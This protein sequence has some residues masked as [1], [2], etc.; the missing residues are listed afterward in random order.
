MYAPQGFIL[1]CPNLQQ[2][3]KFS[4]LGGWKQIAVKPRLLVHVG[5]Y[6]TR[7]V[8]ESVIAWVTRNKLL[9][10]GFAQFCVQQ[11]SPNNGA[12]DTLSII[13]D[14]HRPPT[15]Q[16]IISNCWCAHIS[17]CFIGPKRTC[18][19]LH[20]LGHTMGMH[21]CVLMVHTREPMRSLPFDLSEGA[22]WAC[23]IIWVHPTK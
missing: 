2:V 5:H 23:D 4:F 1:Q 14:Q 18:I 10:P 16:S 7:L 21:L 11:P 20:G 3:S 22:L 17:S 6:E 12:A 19:N 13:T 8:H 15:P 9:H